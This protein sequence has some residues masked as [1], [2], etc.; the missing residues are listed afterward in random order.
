MIKPQIYLDKILDCF[1]S[2]KPESITVGGSYSTVE[3]CCFHI[4][5]E[6]YWMSDFDLMCIDPIAYTENEITNIYKN[7]W[8][9]GQRLSQKNP[10]FHIGLKIRTP[11]EVN[12][13]GLSM[14]Y[15]ELS[16]TGKVIKGP[17]F[18]EYLKNKLVLNP[19]KKKLHDKL[20]SWGLMRLWCNLLFFPIKSVVSP[21]WVEGR[22]W[23]SYF[24]SRGA[25]DWITWDLM[26]RGF[27]SPSYK[28][29][30]N[31]WKNLQQNDADKVELFERCLKFR[32]GEQPADIKEIFSPLLKYSLQQLENFY[33]QKQPDTTK[34]EYL[35]I[36][37]MLQPI[38]TSLDGNPDFRKLNE[39]QKHLK[40]ICGRHLNKPA[41]NNWEL[42]HYLRCEY[43]DFRF[44]RSYSDRKDHHVYTTNFLKMGYL[45]R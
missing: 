9:L 37:A 17:H 7:M 36:C 35:F 16:H 33:N 29:R 6:N 43:S 5:G 21:N 27:W 25:M 20:F 31:D 44:S 42:W 26:D 10:Y 18:R 40:T 45:D 15:N 2:H 4:E 41:Y 38:A 13:E 1:G 32:L 19:A 11:E 24:V 30:F 3:E 12:S 39:A 23:Y 34:T 28:Q 8:N 22:F 14:Y